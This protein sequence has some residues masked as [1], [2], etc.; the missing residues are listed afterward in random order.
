MVVLFM[1]ASRIETQLE[2]W[3]VQ[4]ARWA[5]LAA[6]CGARV[7]AMDFDADFVWRERANVVLRGLLRVV[8]IVGVTL[9]ELWRGCFGSGFAMIMPP[10]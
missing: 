10:T 7:P 2:V 3:R 8:F 5:H 6:M 4:E 1:T 9:G